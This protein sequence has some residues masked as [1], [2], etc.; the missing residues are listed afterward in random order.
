VPAADEDSHNLFQ[1]KN[2]HHTGIAIEAR[3]QK[4]T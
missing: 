1:L 3:Q 2:C 4:T